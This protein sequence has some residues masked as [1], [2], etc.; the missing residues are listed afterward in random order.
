[1]IPEQ[2][3]FLAVITRVMAFRQA[4]AM[5]FLA[6]PLR[7]VFVSRSISFLTELTYGF[8]FLAK[9]SLVVPIRGDP[10]C[11]LA[12]LPC[13]VKNLIPGSILP[14]W[15]ATEQISKLVSC[16][17]KI[18]QVTSR[19]TLQWFFSKKISSWSFNS[20]YIYTLPYC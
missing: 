12:T 8:E 4:M 10:T 17:H 2:H 18:L 7:K 15:F 9:V 16:Q 13:Y 3:Q 11:S 14:Q 5:G 19:P 6:K 20:L 1:M